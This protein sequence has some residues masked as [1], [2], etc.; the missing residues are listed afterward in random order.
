MTFCAHCNEDSAEEAITDVLILGIRERN[1]MT[2][3]F[4]R[5]AGRLKAEYRRVSLADCCALASPF[6]RSNLFDSFGIT[7]RKRAASMAWRRASISA[8]EPRA[9]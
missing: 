3:E 7:Q 4:W 5:T 2:P 6:V 9:M 8:S 1:D